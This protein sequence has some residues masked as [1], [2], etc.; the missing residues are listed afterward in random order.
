MWCGIGLAALLFAGGA[1]AA[2]PSTPTS[3]LA[4]A[5]GTGE[6]ASVE[7][8]EQDA[9]PRI[10]EFFGR[11]VWPI[12][13]KPDSIAFALAERSGS[14][15]GRLAERRQYTVTVKGK[16]GQRSFSVLVYLP[17]AE[18]SRGKVPAFIC[19]NFYGNHTVSSEPEVFIP[20]CPH[21]RKSPAGMAEREAMRGTKHSRVPVAD[22]VS[23]GFAIATFCYSEIYPD[24]GGKD[25]SADSIYT[26]FAPGES[27]EKTA[28]GAWAWADMRARDLI[29][30]L[31]EIDQSRVALAGHSRLAH[32]AAVAAANDTRFACVCLNNG[33]GKSIRLWPNLLYP[34]WMS[35]NMRRYVNLNV[36]GVPAHEL[37]RLRAEGGWP[38]PPY[39]QWHLLAC[40]APRLLYIDAASRCTTAPPDIQLKAILNACPV[41]RLYGKTN[42]PAAGFAGETG[43]VFHGDVGYHVKEGPHSITEFDWKNFMDFLEK[44]GWNAGK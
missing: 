21:L 39:D 18:S 27:G 44:H 3:V 29:E 41:F 16:G 26:I 7:Q 10:L 30:M 6:I 42:L 43:C 36:T 23:R 37:E 19:Q 40:V 2:P 35:E 38:D 12:P 8:W 14:A 20:T 17:K 13:P 33:G 31:P 24:F 34:V 1:C 32:T 5:D 28:L 11:E 15:L 4:R 25:G 9:R 22:I